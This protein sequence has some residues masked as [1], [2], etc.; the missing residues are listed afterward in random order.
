MCMAKNKGDKDVMR[1]NREIHITFRNPN[2][3]KESEKMAELFIKQ[4]ADK[5]FRRTIL[6]AKSKQES[7]K[8]E[9]L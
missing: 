7:N 4:A 1:K 6:D 5:L 3:D 9:K 2:D 8:D